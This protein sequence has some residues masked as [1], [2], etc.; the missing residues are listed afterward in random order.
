MVRD[1]LRI[2]DLDLE[3]GRDEVLNSHDSFKYAG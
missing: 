2:F 1:I 3:P